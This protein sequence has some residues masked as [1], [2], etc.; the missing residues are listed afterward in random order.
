[1]TNATPTTVP[2]LDAA[3]KALAAAE[4]KH[5]TMIGKLNAARAN[6][7]PA[8]ARR[9]EIIR[10][11]AAG[12]EIDINC[13]HEAD[14]E[15]LAVEREIR[16]AVDAEAL[17]WPDVEKA[18]T[19]IKKAID[20]QKFR[21]LRRAIQGFLDSMQEGDELGRTMTAYLASHQAT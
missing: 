10:A 15:I 19:R 18:Q 7:D 16:A 9:D 12:S 6:L 5:G 13:L 17:S 2:G 20:A 3:H 11:M 21:E 8:Q 4:L 1:M 14:E